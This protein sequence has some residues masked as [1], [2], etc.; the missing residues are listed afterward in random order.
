MP[1]LHF[2]AEDKRQAL[3][4]SLTAGHLGMVTIR[5][6]DADDCEGLECG[7]RLEAALSTEDLA[8]WHETH[9]ERPPVA[10]HSHLIAS[11]KNPETLESVYA[12]FKHQPHEPGR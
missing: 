4:S 1:I 11:G 10:A 3:L 2:T 5:L 8:L 7:E 9:A 12:I 6:E